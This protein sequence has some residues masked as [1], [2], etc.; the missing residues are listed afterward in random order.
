MKTKLAE[1]LG[2]VFT[3]IA[4]AMSRNFGIEV[5]PSGFACNTDGV[6][7]IRIPFNADDMTEADQKVLHGMLDHE[8][9]HV[10]E[11]REA[12]EAKAAG[13]AVLTPMD[14]MKRCK[15]KREKMLLN[16]FEDVRIETK[17]SKRAVGIAENLR[18]ANLN[19]VEMFKRR[20]EADGME[21]A[22]F[23]HALG[24]AII[25]K[26]RGFSTEWVPTG[27]LPYLAMVEDEIQ[28]S[29]TTRRVEDCHKLALAVLKKVGDKVGEIGREQEKRREEKRKAKEEAEKAEREKA[30]KGDE[31]ADGEEADEGA[32]GDEEGDEGEGEGDEEGDG[33]DKGSEEGQ[34]E[35]GSKAKDGEGDENSEAGD[36]D[37]EGDEGEGDEEAEGGAGGDGKGE[38]DL[39]EMTDEELAEAGD[40]GANATGSD[41][42]ASDLLDEV[43]D[44]VKSAAVD[45]A[46]DHR[47]YIPSPIA[48]KGDKWIKPDGDQADYEK[49]REEVNS[50]I[51]AMKAK[52]LTLIRSRSASLYEG[53]HERGEI[54]TASLYS[55]RLGN[56]RV[57]SERM[58]ESTLDTAVSVVIDLSGSMGSGMQRGNGA[59]AA[60][61]MAIA[62]GETFAALNIP[63]EIIGFHNPGDAYSSP[64]SPE[65]FSWSRWLSFEF[66]VFKAFNETYRATKQR[67]SSITG[68]SENVD[69]EAV[70][71]IARRLAARD[72]SRKILFVLSDGQPCG[73][74]DD[75]KARAH[76]QDV[77]KLIT[78]S[79][80]EVFGIGAHSAH[81][82]SYYGREQGASYIV[83]N[84]ISNLAVEVY[85]LMK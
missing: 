8:V 77:V 2:G 58:P 38:G 4:R 22:N 18:A 16:V 57:F 25:L 45:D 11:E 62:L 6:N 39:S 24:S 69:G 79:G 61:L 56:K 49:A 54:D 34:D 67:L 31:E 47:R 53:D 84:D 81:V 28:A 23:W 37:S 44:Q 12:A 59:H 19:S 13:E 46:K 51:H 63:F 7:T 30:E 5:V 85:R 73:G 27:M 17:Q 55:L 29:K 20:H 15:T 9:G 76:L 35:G 41:A 50:Q 52:M 10:V 60:K 82:K 65:G 36:A 26:A 14:V 48:Q 33:A 64:T 72:E 70:L 80:I 21:H 83:V 43:K 71:A 3:K 68:H 42:D 75:A 66:H 40:V 32:E 78:S 74:C 1:K